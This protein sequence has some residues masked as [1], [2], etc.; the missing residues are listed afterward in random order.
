MLLNNVFLFRRFISCRRFSASRRSSALWSPS[1]SIESV[2][3]HSVARNQRRVA[4]VVSLEYNKLWRGGV[5]LHNSLPLCDKSRQRYARRLLLTRQPDA[6]WYTFMLGHLWM[7]VTHLSVS[8]VCFLNAD[9]RRRGGGYYNPLN[10]DCSIQFV[11]AKGEEEVK[12][13]GDLFSRC[14]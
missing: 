14:L 13:K 11:S 4:L 3:P 6:A 5:W 9:C 8:A 2:S 1:N 7:Y 12:V 10:G